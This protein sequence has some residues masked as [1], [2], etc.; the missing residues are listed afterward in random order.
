RVHRLPTAPEA[1][2]AGTMVRAAHVRLPRP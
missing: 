2:E 1:P